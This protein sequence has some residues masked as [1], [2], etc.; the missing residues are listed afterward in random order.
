MDTTE[1]DQEETRVRN[2]N[3]FALDTTDSGTGE[4]QWSSILSL[5]ILRRPDQEETRVWRFQHICLRY[6]GLGYGRRYGSGD[7]NSS[8]DTTDG[9]EEG[10]DSN[11]FTLDTTDSG[12]GG[13]TAVVTPFLIGH[14]G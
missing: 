11:T 8:L 10:S 4:M 1:T 9:S 5:W 6:H 2:S 13:D 3:I 7:S 14:Y 12:T